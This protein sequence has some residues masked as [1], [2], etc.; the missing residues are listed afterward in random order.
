M[1]VD[2]L[3]A[4]R[5]FFDP[6]PLQPSLRKTRVVAPGPSEAM[7]LRLA[8]I[9]LETGYSGGRLFP[10]STRVCALDYALPDRDP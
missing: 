7:P 3:H 9:W 4:T 8:G 5:A 10:E 2:H 1:E 6:A